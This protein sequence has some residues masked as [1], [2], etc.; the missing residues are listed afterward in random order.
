MSV[1]I[2]FAFSPQNLDGDTIL[3]VFHVELYGTNIVLGWFDVLP[4]G[5][6][7]TNTFFILAFHPHHISAFDHQKQIFSKNVVFLFVCCMCGQGKHI[8]LSCDLTQVT[9]TCPFQEILVTVPLFSHFIVNSTKQPVDSKYSICKHC[10]WIYPHYHGCD[11]TFA[12]W[13]SFFYIWCESFG[14]K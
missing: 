9:C 7:L 14:P 13:K 4:S 2:V 11:L 3:S 12:A 5:H 10:F 1:W 8:W 6:V